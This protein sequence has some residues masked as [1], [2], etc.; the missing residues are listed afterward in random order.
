MASGAGFLEGEAV[1]DRVEVRGV[2]S[3]TIDAAHFTVEVVGDPGVAAVTVVSRMSARFHRS[4][5][6]RIA[7][8]RDG[9]AATVAVRYDGRPLS[10]AAAAWGPRLLLRAPERTA[11]AV[12]TTAGDVRVHDVAAPQ[13]TIVTTAGDVYLSDVT[14][15]VDVTARAAFIVLE[16]VH[17]AKRITADAGSIRVAD[18]RG[19]L[20]TDTGGE[21]RLRRIDGD[22]SVASAEGLTLT[23][24]R[25][26]LT[27]RSASGQRSAL[28]E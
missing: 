5:D 10:R 9:A 7:V 18:S 8:E 15:A 6:G 25:G 24:H 4:H 17:G 27:I 11:L 23:G 21:Q 12:T 1:E 28:G 26:A 13:V 16:R 14:A 20:F 19:P 3:L 22:V 2:E